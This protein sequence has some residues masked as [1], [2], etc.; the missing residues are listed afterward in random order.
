MK[1]PLELNT[2]V[3]PPHITQQVN[4]KD[5]SCWDWGWTGVLRKS[6]LA[7]S[8]KEDWVHLNLNTD[9]HTASSILSLFF[10]IN[11]LKTTEMRGYLF[12]FGL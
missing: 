4:V 9:L 11:L 7:L 8:D 10:F 1:H 6:G 2:K 3:S 5:K 12:N